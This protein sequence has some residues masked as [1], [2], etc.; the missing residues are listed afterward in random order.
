MEKYKRRENNQKAIKKK[1]NRAEFL[2]F[3]F[4]FIQYCQLAE[5]TAGSIFATDG[6]IPLP[7]ASLLEELGDGDD[8]DAINAA[9]AA[10]LR[11]FLFARRPLPE[12][13]D[14]QTKEPDPETAG[15]LPIK[16][17]PER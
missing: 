2:D 14:P 11:A 8:P 4:Y 1:Q 7:L 17:S 5:T 9:S 3:I 15:L 16:S 6:E 12:G 10:A 13:L